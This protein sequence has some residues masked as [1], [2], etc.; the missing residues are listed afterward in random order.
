MKRFFPATNDST[1]YDLIVV[2]GGITGAAVAHEAATAGLRV[3]LFEKG[4]FGGA[5][6]AAT[7]KLIHGGLRYLK[8]MEFGLVRESLSERRILEDIAPNF[9]YPLPFIVPHYSSA[10]KWMLTAGLTLYDLLSFDRGWTRHASKR[11]PSH[12]RLSAAEVSELAPVLPQEGLVGGKM[13]YDCQSISP[14]RLT[15][16]FIK[17]AAA[18]GARVANYARVEDFLHETGT[19]GARITGVRVR[20]LL[21]G[22]ESTVRGRL[23]LNSGGPW[24]ER[25]LDL[26]ERSEREAGAGAKAAGQLRM[27]EGI[28]LIV[29][30]L[31][32]SETA[33]VLLTPHGRHFFVLPWRGHSL[34]GTTDKP[35]TGDPDAYRVTRE[36]IQEFLDEINATLRHTDLKYEDVVFAYG[37]LRPLTDTQTESTYTSSRK[38]EIYDGADRGLPGLLTV[39][40]GKYTTSRHLAENVLERIAKILERDVHARTD[41]RPLFGCEIPHMDVFLPKVR[42]EY[43]EF[44]RE[45]LDTVARNYGTEYREVLELARSDAGLAESLNDDGELLAQVVFAV[46]HEM[47]HSLEDVLLRRTGLGTLGLPPAEVMEKV[48]ARIAS[49]A[50]RDPAEVKDEIAQVRE[51]WSLPV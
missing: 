46:R 29:P 39:E 20:D 19:G 27:S 8:T 18:S 48:A 44:S 21:T 22:A 26:A 5:T 40:G 42:D 28:H 4:D 17:S 11:I 30:P 32:E 31:V 6:S 43:P 3:I 51:R 49:E 7:S 34:I 37:G 50:G 2:G 45:T 47:A 10:E 35:Y 12:R 15:L 25:L 9:V 1:E 33:L 14:E 23:V 16:A 38:Y 13:Y 41:R 24:A 36:S